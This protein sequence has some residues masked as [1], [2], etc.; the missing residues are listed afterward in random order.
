M[1]GVTIGGCVAFA[2]LNVWNCNED[3]F[4]D[5]V[6][7]IT[8]RIEPESAHK[9]AVIA[10]KYCVIRKQAQPEPDTLVTIHSFNNSL[11]CYVNMFN[12]IDIL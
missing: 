1:F 6:M 11:K 9:L 7:P 10:M 8:A 5:F 12:S 4:R 3:F 2:G